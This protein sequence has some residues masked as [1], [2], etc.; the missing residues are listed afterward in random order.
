MTAMVT[1]ATEATERR[2]ILSGQSDLLKHHRILDVQILP[3]AG[4]VSMA[5]EAS[6]GH[7]G[8]GWQLQSLRLLRPLPIKPDQEAEVCASAE[9][10]GD[11]ALTVRVRSHPVGAEDGWL[12]HASGVA[13]PVSP[14][15]PETI[16]LAAIQARA[17]GIAAKEEI[18]QV[19]A[20]TGI[21]L[22]T[23]FQVVQ[24][25]WLISQHETLAELK[26]GEAARAALPG[27]DFNPALLDGCFQAT[28]GV[29]LPRMLS[30][31]PT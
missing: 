14:L 18:Y 8:G 31:L 27:H 1:A 17:T 12:E 13:V 2:T 10:R 21:A 15:S 24:R 20:L 3:G 4:F 9:P 29:V 6:A 25:S 7:A 19:Y 30:E 26:F 22:G 11:G 5:I 16:D 23:A 28:Y